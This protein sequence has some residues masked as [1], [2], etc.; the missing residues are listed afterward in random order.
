[1][2]SSDKILNNKNIFKSL[3]EYVGK[4][5]EINICPVNMIGGGIGWSPESRE[6]GVYPSVDKIIAIGDIHGDFDALVTALYKAKIIDEDGN[7]WNEN[8]VNSNTI[9]IQLGD[10][11]DRGGRDDGVDSDN[12]KE[13]IDILQFIEHLN[14]KNN[15]GRCGSAF[16]TLLGNHEI[17]NLMGDYR[18]VS[19]SAMKGMGGDEGRRELFKPGGPISKHLGCTCHGIC[20]I[21]DWIF[22]HGGIL[23]KHIKNPEFTIGKFNKLVRDILMGNKVK[24]LT[25]NVKELNPNVKELNKDEK[26]LIFGTDGLFWTRELSDQNKP[27]CAAAK[28]SLEM[29][30]GSSSSGGIVVGHTIQTD[31]INGQCD[32]RVWRIDSG[33][34][35]AFGGNNKNKIEVLKIDNNGVSVI[36]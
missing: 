4:L 23:P 25:P 33:M 13:E 30:N 14:D 15:A 5:N 19:Q 8:N 10:L 27:N 21:G 20:K 28:K 31:G 36:K 35:Q 34:S 9:V 32:N 26:E 18:Y 22:V 12:Y 16:I 3:E 2:I 7:W 6:L 11:L 17:M 1:M 29:M 24:E